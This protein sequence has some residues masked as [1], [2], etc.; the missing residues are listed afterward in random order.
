MAKP[1][2]ISL[3]SF[4]SL[5][6]P[7]A[8]GMALCAGAGCS[9]GTNEQ[10]V[11][12]GELQ[13]Y[14]VE[15]GG[16]R[17][18]TGYSLELDSGKRVELRFA[19]EPELEPGA[20]IRVRGTETSGPGR[21]SQR[22]I[23]VQS[24]ELVGQASTVRAKT[25]A[26]AL[27]QPRTVKVAMLVL[28]IQGAAA[29]GFTVAD[30][31][32]R[33][34]KVKDYYLEISYGN[35]IVDGS[36]F[37]TYSIPQPA[38]CDMETVAELGRQAAEDANVDLSE[39]Q[40][41]GYIV[42]ENSASGINC[43][44]AF[45]DGGRSPAT[46]SPRLG[47]STVYADCKDD[48]AFTHEL[49]HSFGLA[50]AETFT[51]GG[52]PY[53][54]NA[55]TSCTIASYGNHFNTMGNG[56]GHMNAFQK[57]T[58]KWLDAC[59]GQRVRR[60]GTF[61]LTAIQLATSDLQALQIPTGEVYRGQPLYYYVEYRNP[62]L[63]DFNTSIETS[64]GIH[65][66]VAPDFRTNGG[67]TRPMLLDM[68]PAFLGHDDPRLT[69]GNTFTDPDNRVAITFQSATSTSAQVLV[70]YPN[71]GAG[72]NRCWD[73]SV[74]EAPAPAAAQVS[75]DCDY[76]G[77]Q[78]LLQPGNYVLSQLEALGIPNDD[79]SALRVA[80]GYEAILYEDDDFGGAT[81]RITGNAS[82]L[83]DQDFNDYTSSLKIQKIPVPP[84]AVLY[85]DCGI[86]GLELA[87]PVGNYTAAQLAA[88]GFANNSLSSLFVP[89][90]LRVVAYDDDNF[91]GNSRILT[92]VTECLVDLGFNDVASSIKVEVV[93]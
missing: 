4:R 88:A 38:N 22:A 19:S 9:A 25:Q 14:F 67:D 16:G 33:L 47:T 59:N 84:T 49:G 56:L 79:A 69:V 30:A 50:H 58:M 39:Y 48:N 87:L 72:D 42:P 18:T 27:G 75:Q 6:S 5:V 20:R 35:W 55:Y 13:L 36:A 89:G 24:F 82:C 54:R 91:T 71:G 23:E 73:G 80:E 93:D 74:P 43:P 70:Q 15:E 7:I 31:Q 62:A 34:Q 64:A 52:A 12:E 53:V 41:V 17:E 8:M 46:V 86:G 21:V 76:G 37:G 11:A 40:H 26:I 66:D 32:Q 61:T 63:A 78:V 90:G 81:R 92:G 3:G 1:S 77:W 85:D 29:Q 83:V 28:D 45:A 51:C 10:P 2:I 57:G 44:C 65:I 68:T 60:D